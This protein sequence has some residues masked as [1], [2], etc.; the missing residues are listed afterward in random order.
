M[1]SD[2]KSVNEHYLILLHAIRELVMAMVN[3]VIVLNLILVS[4]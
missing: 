2:D 3:N 4:C 1:A